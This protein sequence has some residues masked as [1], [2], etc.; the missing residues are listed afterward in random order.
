MFFE[1]VTVALG[2]MLRVVKPGGTVALAVW[3]DRAANP[4]FSI[5]TEV[6]ARYLPSPPEDPDAPGAFRFAEPGKLA[7]L[8]SQAGAAGVREQVVDFHIE[9]AMTPAEF[10]QLRSEISDS[11]R[12][13][14]ARLTEGELVQVVREVSE[15]LQPFSSAGHLRMPAPSLR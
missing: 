10:W 7:A 15:R 6:L 8:L 4:F 12:A 2:E 5:V 1:D 14:V 3:G 9:A 13:K 11:L